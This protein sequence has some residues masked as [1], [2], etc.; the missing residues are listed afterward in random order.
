MKA[1]YKPLLLAGMLSGTYNP[2]GPYLVNMD[3]T[4]R[5]NLSCP[6]ATSIPHTSKRSGST[7]ARAIDIKLEHFASA[8]RDLAA[9]GT[10]TVQ[11]VGRG[12]SLLHPEFARLTEIAKGHGLEVRLFTNGTLF[13]QKSCEQLVR[14]QVDDINLSLWASCKESY[15]RL[16]GPGSEKRFETIVKGIKL[17]NQTKASHNS[18]YP[19]LTLGYGISPTALD[20]L[21]GVLE[22]ARNMKLNGLCLSVVSVGRGMEDV[23]PGVLDRGGKLEAIE[24]LEKMRPA[25]RASGLEH[26]LNQVISRLE[27]GEDCWLKVPCNI[28][29][30]FS[31]ITVEGK[32]LAC[33]RHEAE[34]GELATQGFKS[35]W[36]SPKYR[37]FR[38]QSRD[39]D[40]LRKAFPKRR[41]QPLLPLCP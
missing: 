25:I 19:K 4:H 36:N 23:R 2:V 12:E 15:A 10:R 21:Q 1:L 28:A 17:L 20:D 33:N 27:A 37:D 3:L 22:F 29:W 40:Y 31:T 41:V 7:P 26:N 38:K 16:H 13:D 35:I 30:F 8:C 14:A 34:M 32:V 18:L 11:M 39:P 9:L 24:R 6:G 5:C